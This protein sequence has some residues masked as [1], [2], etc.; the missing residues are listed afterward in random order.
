[1]L[2]A[3]AS[4]TRATSVDLSEATGIHRTTV[5]RLLETLC[6]QG[7]VRLSPSDETY[8]LTRRTHSFCVAPI[9]YVALT[10]V[11]VP[12]LADL[13]RAIQWP[14]EFAIPSGGE[15]LVH[16]S[17]HRQSPVAIESST[18]GRRYP[19]LTSA[20]G[21]AYLSFTDDATRRVLTRSLGA[22][23]DGPA[24]HGLESLIARIRRRGYAECMRDPGAKMASIALPVRYAGRVSAC[25]SISYFSSAMRPA[26][27]AAQYLPLLQAA[28]EKM[29]NSALVLD[30]PLGQRVARKPAVL[31]ASSS[32]GI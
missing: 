6:E 24:G 32:L 17:T 30:V 13:V 25:V 10:E 31:E 19:M 21:Q 3:L 20:L 26:D 29:E 4:M 16:E 18:V 7:Y 22:G 15:M 28:V 8:R 12:I 2:N 1:V 5:K 11:A 27:A 9:S 14:S 23:D